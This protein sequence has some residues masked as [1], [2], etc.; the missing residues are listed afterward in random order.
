MSMSPST[1]RALGTKIISIT[2]AGR[3]HDACFAP[4]GSEAK[5]DAVD[6]IWY[7]WCGPKSPLFGK[8][9]LAAFERYFIEDPKTHTETLNP[10]YRLVEERP[11]CREDFA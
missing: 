7:L 4:A 8:S 3:V 1:A 5:Q 9:K 6:F 10:Y 2:S 11:A